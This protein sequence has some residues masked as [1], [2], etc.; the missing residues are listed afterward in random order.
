MNPRWRDY[1]VGGGAAILAVWLSFDLADGNIA[2]P[3]LAVTVAVG[4]IL[5]RLT[6]TPIDVIALGVLLIGYLVGNRG[7]AQLMLLPGVPLLPAEFTL[8]LA[9]GVLILRSALTKT[10]PWRRNALNYALLLWLVVGT[11]RAL[12]N[13]REYGF[14]A[15]R[16]FAMVYYVAFFFLAQAIATEEK[17]RRF[18]L[19]CLFGA[20][21]GLPVVFLLSELFPNFF[22]ATLALRGVPLIFFK[23]D[24]APTFFSVSAVLLFLGSPPC[25]RW[26][27]RPLAIVMILW[28]FAGDNRASI[29]GTLV[30]L[31]WVLLSR[32]RRFA[33]LQIGVAALGL[34]LFAGFASLSGNTWAEQR[35][36]GMTDRAMSVV[37]LAGKFSYRGEDSSI[38]T[39]N[40]RFR[41]VWWQTVV[42]ET[43]DTNPAFGL[44]FGYDL[45]RGFLREYNPDMAEDFTARSP[46]NILVTVF[47]R[48]G[49]VGLVIF[50]VFLAVFAARTWRIVRSPTSDATEVALW[51]GLWVIATSAC[52]G[53]VLEGPMGAVLFWTILGL[54]SAPDESESAPPSAGEIPA[55]TPDPSLPEAPPGREVVP[56][57]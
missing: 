52:L 41:W 1:L 4:A 13:L 46:H 36:H 34:L 25:H 40:N 42:Q 15:V 23:G 50:L 51:S 24:L 9:S 7:F 44:G 11:S 38:K 56:S 32:F 5:V 29:L 8:M 39:D 43:M 26:W 33:L 16:D 2:G 27:A 54:A 49:L 21:A 6:R 48:M 3:L 30:M 14:V 10:L 55:T 47:G 19:R 20:S 28:V 31:A 53:V 17:N 22:F 12:F 18:L 45:A 35:F 37:D 57:P